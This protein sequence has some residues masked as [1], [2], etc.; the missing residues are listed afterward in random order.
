MQRVRY[1]LAQIFCR[2]LPPIL[3]QSFRNILIKLPEGVNLNKD[4][5]TKSFTGSNFYGNTVDFHAFKFA[6][7]GFFDWRNIVI[8]EQVLRSISGGIIEVGANIGTETI[9]YADVAHRHRQNVIAFEPLLSNFRILNSNIEKNGFT[10]VE[11]VNS[12]VSDKSGRA[13]FQVPASNDSG[14]GHITTIS[15]P[16]TIATNVTTLDEY[17][18]NS[19]TALVAMDVEGF[20]YQV[21][22]GSKNLIATQRP[23]FIVEVNLNYLNNRAKVT[24]SEFYNFFISNNYLCYYVNKLGLEL[25]DIEAFKVKTNKNWVCIPVENSTVAQ[26]ISTSIFLNGINPI[27]KYY[28]FK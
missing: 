13:N 27:F 25:V 23:V 16:T 11:T 4:F 28:H 3:S 18:K 19:L 7:H 26:R 24:L 2:V 8:A 12:L 20:E 5:I 22:L 1:K 6:I 10:N 9:S 21:L 17:C 15:S 14:S